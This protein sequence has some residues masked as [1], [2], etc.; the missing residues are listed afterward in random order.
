MELTFKINLFSFIVV[1]GSLYTILDSRTATIG[2]LDIFANG[3]EET[4]ILCPQASGRVHYVHLSGTPNIHY[5]AAI[6]DKLAE[7]SLNTPVS[8]QASK[9]NDLV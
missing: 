8:F 5:T 4:I 3:P 2:E 1:I 7:I 6:T 9:K